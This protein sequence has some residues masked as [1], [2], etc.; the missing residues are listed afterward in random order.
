MIYDQEEKLTNQELLGKVHGTY[1]ES[2][3]IDWFHL[4]QEKYKNNSIF[5]DIMV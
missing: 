5:I 4:I 2:N 1:L 3:M